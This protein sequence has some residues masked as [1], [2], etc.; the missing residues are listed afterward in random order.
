MRTIRKTSVSATSRIK[1]IVMRNNDLNRW[2]LES[3]LH[4]IHFDNNRFFYRIER[5]IGIVLC[6]YNLRVS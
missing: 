3:N 2:P 1:I 6:E 4:C 5:N